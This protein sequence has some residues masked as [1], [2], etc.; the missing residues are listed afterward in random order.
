MNEHILVHSGGILFGIILIVLGIRYKISEYL[1]PGILW[2]SANAIFLA[3]GEHVYDGI[4]Q[5]DSILFCIIFMV[6]PAFFMGLLVLKGTYR[7]NDQLIRLLALIVIF[8]DC[9]HIYQKQPMILLVM[10][11]LLILVRA[12]R[13]RHYDDIHP[14]IQLNEPYISDSDILF[15]IPKLNGVPITNDPEFVDYIK[16]IS[17]GK[18]LAMHGVYHSPEG[19]FRT[20]EFGYP[21]SKEYVIEGMKIFE[22]AFGYKPTIFKAPCYNLV[23]ENK[24]IIEELGMRVEDVDS[25]MFNKV[26]H[27]NYGMFMRS[28]NFLEYVL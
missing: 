7:R 24:K 12:F 17:K 15:V 18:T 16:K 13:K 10:I 9:Y 4:L 25:L 3:Y 28:V 26:Y 14:H 20:A 1:I 19:Y 11:V 21:R 8:V 6:I 23:N 27:P 22:E 5:Y 2:F